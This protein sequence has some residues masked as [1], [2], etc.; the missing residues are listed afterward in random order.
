MDSDFQGNYNKMKKILS[1]TLGVALVFALA[2]FAADDKKHEDK[3]HDD[4]KH[5][6]K[7]DHKE[8]KKKDH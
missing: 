2:S 1:M 6:D 7:K 3:K 5:G 4:K 8:D